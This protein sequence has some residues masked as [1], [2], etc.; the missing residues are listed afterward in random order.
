METRK[1]KK[2]RTRKVRVDT[3]DAAQDF[4]IIGCVDRSPPASTI[5][6]L[7]FF[8]IIRLEIDEVVEMAPDVKSRYADAK[9]AF[10]Y[11]NNKDNRYE[12]TLLTDVPFTLEHTLVYQEKLGSKPWYANN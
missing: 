9:S 12:Y 3:H 11:D 8:N 6:F 4:Q 2:G 1:D 7:K 10:I 5:D